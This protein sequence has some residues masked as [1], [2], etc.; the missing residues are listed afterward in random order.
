M[1]YRGDPEWWAI[2]V[3]LIKERIDLENA[4]ALDIGF[5]TGGFSLAIAQEGS[6]LVNLDITFYRAGPM[7]ARMKGGDVHHQFL[8]HPKFASAVSLPYK[9]N[10]FDLIILNGVL[11]YTAQGQG[12]SPRDTHLRVLKYIRKLLKPEGLF[13]FGIEN[14]YYMKFLLGW[15]DHFEMRF[16]NVLPRKLS[17]FISKHILKKEI[18]NWIYSHDEYVKLLSEAGF[19][20]PMFFTALPNYKSP[21][22]II[23]LTDICE[24][25]DVILK[26]H[27]KKLYKYVC[28]LLAHSDW[29]YRKIGPDFII[30]SGVR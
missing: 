18:R 3:A 17:T 11:E 25:R 9:E 24:S 26:T 8:H 15:R 22:Y 16:S 14:R 12:G 1:N 6:I 13:Y 10:I 27:T 2:S 23:P 19:N 4:K 30:L 20:D 21:E 28:Y 7:L 29:L 5:G